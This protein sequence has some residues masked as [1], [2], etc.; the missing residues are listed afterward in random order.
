MVATVCYRC[1]REQVWVR[2]RPHYYGMGYLMTRGY[3]TTELLSFYRGLLSLDDIKLSPPWYYW[4][5]TDICDRQISSRYLLSGGSGRVEHLNIGVTLI[6]YTGRNT[7]DGIVLICCSPLVDRYLR[8]PWYWLYFT[9][10][11]C[12]LRSKLLSWF[13]KS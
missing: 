12:R 7:E 11:L 13:R 9:S 10:T 2:G 4:E 5:Q 6:N 8:S 3:L 1:L